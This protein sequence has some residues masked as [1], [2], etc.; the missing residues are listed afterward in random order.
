MATVDQVL[1]RVNDALD[2]LAETGEAVGE[3][4]QYVTDLRGAWLARLAEV[5]AARGTDPV[6]PAVEA[7]V[8]RAS[9][10]VGRIT[11]PHRA[12]DWLSTFPQIVLLALDEP[13]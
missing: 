13:T 10:E 9:E 3:E 12:I 8:A 4:W 5:S 7:A 1:A 2:A 6:S 11:D